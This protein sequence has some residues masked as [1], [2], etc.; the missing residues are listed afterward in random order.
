MKH[1]T[2]LTILQTL[3]VAD[4]DRWSL[5]IERLCLRNF[6]L[7]ALNFHCHSPLHFLILRSSPS[8]LSSITKWRQHRSLEFPMAE[9]HAGL[10][11]CRNSLYASKELWKHWPG[12]KNHLPLLTAEMCEL[13]Q[14]WKFRRLEYLELNIALKRWLLLHVMAYTSKALQ[15]QTAVVADAFGDAASCVW[16]PLD[17]HLLVG[18]LMK[19]VV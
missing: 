10:W 14:E 7:M 2:L 6:H 19:Q 11:N 4:S 18:L 8:L 15:T 9:S 3:I 5:P 12:T 16:Q 17:V 13:F 1:S